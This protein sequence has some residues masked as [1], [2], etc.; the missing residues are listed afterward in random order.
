MSSSVR[1]R[2]DEGESERTPK[3]KK[4]DDADAVV[5]SEADV[6]ENTQLNEIPLLQKNPLPPS[7]ALLGVPPLDMSESP[8]FRLSESDV[9]ISEYIGR[10]VSKIDGIIK[11]RYLRI[12]A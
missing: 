10:D 9:G 4:V 11:Q 1:A 8:F 5:F 12:H 2:D 7:H 6:V 3:R